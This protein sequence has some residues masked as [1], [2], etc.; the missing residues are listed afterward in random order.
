MNDCLSELWL[1]AA[2]HDFELRAVDL[3]GQSNWAVDL[4]SRWNLSA[5]NA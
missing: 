4:L 3:E 2:I 5:S 1:L